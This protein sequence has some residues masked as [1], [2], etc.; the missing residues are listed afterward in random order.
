MHR[1]QQFF[2]TYERDRTLQNLL[3]HCSKR[4]NRQAKARP[5][6]Q[7]LPTHETQDS[8]LVFVFKYLCLPIARDNSSC[9]LKPPQSGGYWPNKK[10]SRKGSVTRVRPLAMSA[11]AENIWMIRV[12]R[13]IASNCVRTRSKKTAT[14]TNGTPRPAAYNARSNVLCPVLSKL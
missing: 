7:R 1:P 5:L 13:L 10:N 12:Q 3:V 4:K 14:S 9:Q 6:P 8:S 2:S 11:T